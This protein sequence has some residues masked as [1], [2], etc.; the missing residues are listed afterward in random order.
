RLLAVPDPADVRPGL[1]G[2]AVG[3]GLGERDRRRGAE[4]LRAVESPRK[5][6]TTWGNP[7]FPHGPPL[8]E[9]GPGVKVVSWAG[10]FVRAGWVVV[11]VRVGLISL[12]QPRGL[13]S[14]LGACSGSAIPCRAVRRP[15]GPWRLPEQRVRCL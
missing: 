12:W 6:L 5:A 2:Q 1:A 13:R 3:R 9:G 14:W 7:W 11:V 15:R 8:Y 4:D 10:G